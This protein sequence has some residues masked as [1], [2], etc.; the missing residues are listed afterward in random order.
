MENEIRKLYRSYSKNREDDSK[1]L[2]NVYVL[3]KWLEKN[4]IEP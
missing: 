1:K 3:S 4:R 2:W